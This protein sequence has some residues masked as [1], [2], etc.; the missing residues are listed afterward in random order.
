[1]Y[2]YYLDIED[3]IFILVILFLS[4]GGDLRNFMLSAYDLDMTNSGE[5][6][7]ITIELFRSEAWGDFSWKRGWLVDICKIK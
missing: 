6:V 7:F 3:L 4:S 2:I 5:Y 1:M